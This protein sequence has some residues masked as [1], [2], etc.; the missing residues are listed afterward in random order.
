M[1]VRGKSAPTS[2]FNQ[3]LELPIPRDSLGDKL[4]SGGNRVIL[5]LKTAQIFES[6]NCFLV[7]LFCTYLAN[8]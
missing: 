2:R 8:Y 4:S 1:F 7:S 3:E 6:H 5:A